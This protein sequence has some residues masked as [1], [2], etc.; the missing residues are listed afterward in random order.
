[1][2]PDAKL[3]VAKPVGTLKLLERLGRPF[4]GT[5]R[6]GQVLHF[7]NGDGMGFRRIFDLSG[8]QRTRTNQE[9]E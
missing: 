6:Q 8:M 3:G 7:W 2:G 5:G 1:M 4:E 9:L